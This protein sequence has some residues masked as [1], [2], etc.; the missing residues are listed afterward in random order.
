[1]ELVI[2]KPKT[3]P[4]SR[5][6]AD[7]PCSAA[8]EFGAGTACSTV[9]LVSGEAV[10]A[11][12]AAANTLRHMSAASA[13]RRVWIFCEARVVGAGPLGRKDPQVFKPEEWL[14]LF[15]VR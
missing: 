2:G 3:L 1:M 15:G 9:W 4:T 13:T 12:A 8:A 7:K 11:R 14:K 6:F 10:W 5:A